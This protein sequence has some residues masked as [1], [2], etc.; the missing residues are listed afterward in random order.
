[1]AFVSDSLNM[2]HNICQIFFYGPGVKNALS[3]EWIKLIHQ[4]SLEATACINS[5]EEYA[6]QLQQKADSP[7]QVAGMAQLAAASKNAD[8]T[9]TFGLRSN[10]TA[11]TPE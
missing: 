1:M 2:G 9:I 4:Q 6:P 5:V 8:R 3:Q 11:D 10:D 7:V